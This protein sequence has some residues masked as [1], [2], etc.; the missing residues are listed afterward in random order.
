MKKKIL[1]IS[2]A[3]EIGGAEKVILDIA[4]VLKEDYELMLL[5]Q[6]EGAFPSAF[7]AKGLKS[8]K[9]KLP[10]WRKFKSKISRMLA[11][12]KL[13]CLVK[14]ERVDILHC[15]SYR[16]APYV[17]WVMKLSG[18]KG[19]VHLHEHAG[20]RD[21]KKFGVLRFKDILSVAQSVANVLPKDKQ[22]I[23]YNAVDQRIFCPIE[24]KV[25]SKLN[26]GIVA[27]LNPVKRHKLFV[28]VAGAIKKKNDNVV[29]TVVGGDIFS[30]GLQIDDLKKQAIELGLKESIVFTGTVKDPSDYIKEMD[31]FLLTSEKEACPLVLLEAMACGCIVFADINAGGPVELIKNEVDGFLLDFTNIEQSANKIIEII[32]NEQ[33]KNRI[34]DNALMKIKVNFSNPV[35][36]E[37]LVKF[38]E[39]L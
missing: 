39:A 35:F 38:Y 13:Y 16:V 12:Y 28:D 29:F 27:H 26:I 18:V 25:D 30:T 7:E 32:N 11:V 33:L 22:K 19:F 2:A 17:Y 15:N 9:Q 34:I 24:K 6:S 14:N 8:F 3:S 4:D 1:F 10:A 23:L 5:N 36:K 20:Y 31:V 37:R 21:L